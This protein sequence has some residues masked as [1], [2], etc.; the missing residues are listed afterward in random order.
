MNVADLFTRQHPDHRMRNAD[1]SK[2]L[3]EARCKAHPVPDQRACDID[4][5]DAFPCPRR[6]QAHNA[7]PLSP[8]PAHRTMHRLQ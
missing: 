8:N 6:R 3:V 4:S 2:A 5:K 7:R 1:R